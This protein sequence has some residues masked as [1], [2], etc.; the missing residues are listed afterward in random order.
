[1]NIKNK[2]LQIETRVAIEATFSATVPTWKQRLP[3]IVAD[4][5][6]LGPGRVFDGIDRGR[7]AG[8]VAGERCQLP[9]G[10]AA[11][12]AAE[13]NGRDRLHVPGD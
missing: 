2:S 4:D 10:A 8:G 5:L 3:A 9:T 13:T 6:S 1:M 12:R 7:Q 11:E